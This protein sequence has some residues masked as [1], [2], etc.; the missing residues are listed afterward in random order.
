M[1]KITFLCFL[2]CWS[3][4]L[5][6]AQNVYDFGK[7]SPI[8]EKKERRE[9]ATDF[10][11]FPYIHLRFSPSLTLPIGAFGSALDVPRSGFAGMG[12][13]YNADLLLYIFHLERGQGLLAH[14]F[15]MSV[16]GGWSKYPLQDAFE[17]LM[18]NKYNSPAALATKW[19][20][21]RADWRGGHFGLGLAY[22]FIANQRLMIN[23]EA[24]FGGLNLKAPN[25]QIDEGNY[26]PPGYGGFFE[27]ARLPALDDNESVFVGIYQLGIGYMMTKRWGL[28]VGAEL[29]HG[30]REQRA[31]RYVTL[32]S[33]AG[34]SLQRITETYQQPFLALNFQVGLCFSLGGRWEDLHSSDDDD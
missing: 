34:V 16:R 32:P 7:D 13:G 15:G 31:E 3:T 9:R 19:Q 23:V 14:S 20:A 11:D 21:R 26:I 2:A 22:L 30:N 17:E 24:M 8:E 33:G 25:Y 1:K 4:M 28:K 6:Q 29:M 5:L 12:W 10:N 18:E 27:V